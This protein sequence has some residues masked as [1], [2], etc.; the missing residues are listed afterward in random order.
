M[1]NYKLSSKITLVLS[2]CLI[3]LITF[4]FFTGIINPKIQGISSIICI[5]GCSVAITVVEI[6]ERERIKDEK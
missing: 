1:R 2:V 6:L 3:I 5:S 4:N